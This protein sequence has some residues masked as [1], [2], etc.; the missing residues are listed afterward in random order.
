M[1]LA[2]VRNER[3]HENVTDSRHRRGVIGAHGHLSYVY[4][5]YAQLPARTSEL[6]KEHEFGLVAGVPKRHLDSFA[7]VNASGAACN[8]DDVHKA[9]VAQR[10]SQIAPSVGK[11]RRTLDYTIR[12]THTCSSM[13]S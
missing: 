3:A 1:T 2:R 9:Q 6:V 7:S 12:C 5:A 8:R 10:V 11:R 4:G 13:W